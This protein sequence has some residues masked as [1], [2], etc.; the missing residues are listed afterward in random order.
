MTESQGRDRYHFMRR[1]AVIAAWRL[2]IGLALA[3][4]AGCGWLGVRGRND[5]PPP[6]AQQLERMQQI[7]ER[8]Q[9]AIDRGEYEPARVD[10]LEL[11]KE[12][13]DSAEALQRLGTVLQLE[14]RRDEAEACYR[15][16][17][18]RDRDYVE[19]LIGLGDVEAQRGDSASA[20]KRY[21]SAIEID[22][23]RPKAHLSTGRVLEAMGQTDQAL[24]AYFRAL[25]FDGNNSEVILRIAAI[26]LAR[27]QPDQALSRLDQVVELSPNNGEARELRGLAHSKLHHLPEAIA[28]FRAAAQRL[29]GRPDVY[30]HL[31]LALEADNKRADALRAAEQAVRLA[32]TDAAVRGLSE[33]LR[34]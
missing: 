27:D 18:A 23:H 32:P 1:W 7:S 12:E 26:Q 30:Y 17:L 33:R 13:P 16:A 8:A 24:A 25:E 15:G 11:V 20:L 34:R 21:E 14:G 9:A 3:A 5:R 19:A 4:S 2:L 6:T 28:D 31:A 10:L 22:P 29:P